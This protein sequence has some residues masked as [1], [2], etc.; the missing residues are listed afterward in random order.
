MT[1]GCT[2]RRAWATLLLD[3][4]LVDLSSPFAAGGAERNAA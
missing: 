3:S 1:S 4:L 2:I